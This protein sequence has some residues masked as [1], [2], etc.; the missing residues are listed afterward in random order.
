MLW[1]AI[2]A[3]KFDLVGTHGRGSEPPFRARQNQCFRAAR[4]G[5]RFA[6]TA[7]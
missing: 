3:P 4:V 5:K 6:G 1:R 2:D 7:P